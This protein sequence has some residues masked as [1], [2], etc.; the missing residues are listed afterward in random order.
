[1]RMTMTDTATDAPRFAFGK[2]WENFVDKHLTEERVR[3]AQEHLL[4]FLKLP[5][6]TGKRIRVNDE[7]REFS[8]SARPGENLRSYVTRKY[9]LE[10]IRST[11]AKEAEQK[12]LD[13]YAE[14]K[15]AAAKAEWA[16][17]HGTNPDTLIPR[18]SRFDRIS[19]RRFSTG[20]AGTW[21]TIFA[22]WV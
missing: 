19:S 16:K 6:L 11:R 10:N 17:S 5:D 15:L 8:S 3:I 12:K 7:Y 2:N 4:R 1:M 22:K 13:S 21:T 14:E 9:D 18:A 20:S